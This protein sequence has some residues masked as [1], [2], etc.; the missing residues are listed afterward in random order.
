MAKAN[1][2]SKMTWKQIKQPED[3]EEWSVEITMPH[4]EAPIAH[5][6]IWKNLRG[7]FTAA[8]IWLDG[9]GRLTDLKAT[10]I[11]SAKIEAEQ[12]ARG[13]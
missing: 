10:T 12:W 5:L 6:T 4:R 7:R 1:T 3:P 11:E 8:I 13:E 2:K 9:Y